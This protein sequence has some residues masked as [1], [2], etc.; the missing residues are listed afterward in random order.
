M[1]KTSVAFSFYE[2]PNVITFFL[3]CQKQR[4][5]LSLIVFDNKENKRNILLGNFLIANS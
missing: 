2:G 3:L 4:Q 5:R 1:E